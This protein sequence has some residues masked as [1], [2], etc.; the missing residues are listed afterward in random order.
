[1][2]VI[3]LC[4]FIIFL[5]FAMFYIMYS[6]FIDFDQ[7]YND[8]FYMVKN[9]TKNRDGIIFEEIER[10]KNF[11]C[12]DLRFCF[13]DLYEKIKPIPYVEESKVILKKTRKKNND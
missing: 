8:I 11:I 12:K 1:M 10:S 13:D 4:L 3:I 7:K 9:M 5:L 6:Y 2:I